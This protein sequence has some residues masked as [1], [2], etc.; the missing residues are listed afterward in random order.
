MAFTVGVRFANNIYGGMQ[1]VDWAK[2]SGVQQISCLFQ[3][4]KYE[5]GLVSPEISMNKPPFSVWLLTLQANG[6]DTLMG[7]FEIPISF[8]G[9]FFLSF[10]SVFTRCFSKKYV[11]SF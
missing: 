3:K 5:V 1:F 4:T 9:M 11:I 10:Q 7:L 6:I 2:W 8:F